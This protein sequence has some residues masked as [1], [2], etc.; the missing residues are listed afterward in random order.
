MNTRKVSVIAVLAALAIGTNYAMLPL[1]NVKFMDFIVFIGGFCFGPL[2]GAVIGVVTWSVYGSLNPLGFAL[3]VWIATTACEVL[4]GL[5]G[6]LTAKLIHLPNFK[7]AGAS[8]VGASVLFGII[9]LLLTFTY[10]LITNAAYAYAFGINVVVAIVVGFIPFGVAHLL[11]NVVFFSFGCV[12]TINTVNRMIGG[13]RGKGGEQT[14]SN[15]K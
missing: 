8:R 14:V 1:F 13:G 7:E 12:P 11:S 3:P 10:D 15:E 2:V 6:G 5:A 4:F 9:G